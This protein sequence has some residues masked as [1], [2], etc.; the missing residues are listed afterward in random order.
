MAAESTRDRYHRFVTDYN[1]GVARAE[2][3]TTY[4]IPTAQF[5]DFL[6]FLKRQGFHL[7]APV[8]TRFARAHEID[9]EIAGNDLQ[10]V[11]VE[12][13]PGET[14]VA[15]AGAMLYLDPAVQMETIFGDGSA[16]SAGVMGKIFGAGKRILTGESLFMTAFTN[17][18][19]GKQR[20][21]FSAPFPGKILA[22]DLSTLGGELI[23]QKEAF[24]CAAKGVA[25][26]IAFQ[27]KIGVGLFGGEGFILERLRG[28]GY[29]FVHAG[30]TVLE[31]DLAGGETLRVDTGCLVAMQRQVDY[32]IQFV[33]GIK[34]ALFGGEGLFFATLTGPGRVW[35]Q[36][37]PFSRLAGR[38][39]A[40]LPRGGGR[41]QGE[42]SLLGGVGDLLMGD[43]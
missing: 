7:A 29:A 27:R 5:D 3:C 34:S 2:L 16:A 42:G 4:D 26:D 14:V 11:A 9:F 35:L 33:G 15:E 18:G 25:I 23:C 12:L 32:D 28:D 41:R 20:V 10:Y 13:D 17:A 30:G 31:R 8:T 1:R 36:S 39:I 40:A 38:I 22:M 43:R 19:T 37:L 21:A 24:L 6:A